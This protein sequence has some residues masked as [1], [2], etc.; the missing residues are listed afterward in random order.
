MKKHSFLSF[1]KYH[2]N[3]AIRVKLHSLAYRFPAL[4][5]LDELSG[6][7]VTGQ[8]GIKVSLTNRA[9]AAP[10]VKPAIMLALSGTDGARI[11]LQLGVYLIQCLVR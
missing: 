6:H 2:T 11:P 4:L 8:P 9:K 1:T 10:K 7:P 3:E 5:A